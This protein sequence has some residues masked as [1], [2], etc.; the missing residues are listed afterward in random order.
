[1]MIS[2]PGGEVDTR[3]PRV[4][5]CIDF[6]DGDYTDEVPVERRLRCM[7]KAAW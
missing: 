4:A 1:M 5:D 6:S 3:R 7:C 2:G